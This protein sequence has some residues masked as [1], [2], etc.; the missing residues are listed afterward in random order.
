MVTRLNKNLR[1]GIGLVALYTALTGIAMLTDSNYGEGGHYVLPGVILVLLIVEA[2][3]W[4]Q[5][6]L[7]A[8]K[9]SGFIAPTQKGM[10]I[11]TIVS[12]LLLV[13]LAG[14]V[15][16][17]PGEKHMRQNW[18]LALIGLLAQGGLAEELVFRGFLFRRLREGRDFWRAALVSMFPFVLVHLYL[19]A[20]MSFAVAAVAL[21][22]A[23]L[24]SFPFAKL[25]EIG[26]GSIWPCVAL[27]F[28]THLIKLVVFADSSSQI[29]LL[30][31][32]VMVLSVPW[33]VFAFGRPKRQYR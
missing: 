13:G 22:V 28:T 17:M 16:L 8:I 12:A 3:L 21:V 33:M 14:I 27:H 24:T 20:T 11:G 9:E 10:L 6:P 19:F 4:K 23:L 2:L 15:M 7:V 25:F 30:A 18:P 1:I 32:M 29:A 31:W 5:P 26:N